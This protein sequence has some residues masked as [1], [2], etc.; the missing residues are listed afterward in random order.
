MVLTN[1]E[2][3]SSLRERVGRAVRRRWSPTVDGN[4]T[5]VDENEQPMRAELF[6]ISQIEQHAST[7]ASWHQVGFAGG[8]RADHLLLRLA[9]NEQALRDAHVLITEAVEHGTRITPAAE[10]FVDNYHL[11]EEQ[12]RTARR[13]LPRGFS[14]ELPRLANGPFAGTPR[15]YDIAIEL[16]SHSHGRVEIEG[17]RAFVASYQKVSPLRLGE[18]WAIPIML[19]LALIENLRR[20][21]AS[22]TAGRRDRARATH[23]VDRM[24]EIAASDPG[25]VVLILADMVRESPPLTNAFVTEFASRLRGQGAALVFPVSWLEHRLAENGQT[26]ERVFQLVSQNQAA[27]QV[28]IGNSIGSLRF[29]G[30]TDWRNF[31]EAMSVVERTLLADPTGVYATMDFA[32]RDCYRL[33]V[34]EISKRSSLSENDVAQAALQLSQDKPGGRQA[35]IGHFLIDAGRRLL[36]R[37]ARMRRTPRQVAC[38]IGQRLRFAGYASAVVGLTGILTGFL[39]IAAPTNALPTS[40]W[41]LAATLLVFALCSS[42]LSMSMV[43]WAATQ[44][45]LPRRLPRLDFSAGIPQGHSTVVAVPAMLTD[46]G[47][48]DSLVESLEVRFLANR[49]PRLFFALLTDFCDAQEERLAADDALLARAR[50]GIEALNRKYAGDGLPFFL[51]HRNRRWN[52]GEG[53]WMGWE[54][55][56]GKLEQFNDALRADPGQLPTATGFDAI[57]GDLGRLQ[58]VKYVI[59]LDSDTQLPRD[60]AQ[61]LA[62][63]MA[64]PLNC[65]VYDEGLGRVIDGY[66]ILQ[67]RVA[68]TMA[69]VGRSRFAR[70]F[71]GEPGIDPYTRAVSDV[72]QDLFNEGSFVGK[73]IYDVDSFR[74]AIGGKLPDNRILSHDLLEGAYGR[75]GLVSDITLFDD[76]PSSYAADV[77]RRYRW[78]RGDWQITPWL[79]PRVPGRDSS[80]QRNP[81]SWLSQWKILDNL[82]RT[83]VPIGLLSLL[84]Q[85]WIRPGA[86]VFA[87]LVL[88]AFLLLPGLL[89]A[90]TDLLHR[91]DEFPLR[92][93]VQEIGATV[94]RH[95]AREAF[96]L[97]C[98]PYDAFIA[99]TAMLRT[100][101][102]LLFTHRKLLEWRTASDAQRS[103]LT[104]LAGTYAAMWV[105]PFVALAATVGVVRQNPAALAV[106]A[107]VLG[108]WA[109]APVIAW[110]LS[111]PTVRGL[112]RLVPDDLVFLRTVARRTWRYFETFVGPEDNHLPPD[113]FQE[114]PPRG[115]AHRTSPTNIGLALTA[116]LVAY[117]FGYLSGTDV[118]ARTTCTLGAMDKLQRFRGHFY[119][120]YD[121]R[122]L[123]PLRPIYVSTVDSGNLSGHLITLGAGLHEMAGHKVFRTQIFAG[124]VDTLDVINDLLLRSASTSARTTVVRLREQLGSLPQTLSAS[125]ALLEGLLASGRDLVRT[126]GPDSGLAAA[127]DH[128]DGLSWWLGAFE[129]QCQRALEDLR[130]V[131]PWL[132]VPGVAEA[133]HADLNDALSRLDQI[134]SLADTARLAQTLVPVIDGALNARSSADEHTKGLT[135]L[136]AAVTLAVGR[137]SA[138]LSDLRLLIVRCREF[139]DID[140]QFLY[141]RERRMLAIGYSVSDHHLDPSFYDLLASEAR[142]A[143][144]VAI[145]QGKLPQE[146]WFSLGRLL[147]TSAGRPALLSWSGS[148]FEYLMPLLVMPTYE[149]TILDETY[150]GV[151][152][153]QIQHG[154]DRGVPW[155]VSESGYS[156]TD[157]QLN[158]QYR[159]F[160]VPG[161]GFKRGLANDLVIAPYASAMALMVAPTDACANL[162]RLARQGL[163]GA[164]GFYEAVDYTPARLLRGKDP[165]TVR[166]Y[167]AHHQGMSFLSLAYLLLDQPMQRRFN[168]EPAFRA[169]NL[170]LQERVPRTLAIHPHPAEVSAASEAPVDAPNSIRIFNTPATSSPA[171]H[172]LSNGSYHVAITNA[173]GGY[174]R[175]R[176]LAVTRWHEDPTRDCW[177]SFCYLRDVTSGAFWSVAH[178]PT[179]KAA[180]SY[181]AIYSQGRA[182]FRRRDGEIDTHVEISISPEDDIELRRVSLTNIGRTARTIELTSY[183]EVVLSQPAAD[184]AHPTFSN[185]FVQTELLRER[186]AILC[187]RRPRSGA[188]RPPWMLHLMTVLGTCVRATS[189]ETGRTEFIGRGRSAIDPAA[190]HRDALTDSQGSVLDP[191]VAIRNTIVIQPDETV[192]IHIVT[193]VAETRPGAIDLIEKYSD[194]HAADRVFDL[195]WTHSQVLLRQL[196]AAEADTQLYER[197]A[198]SILYANSTLRAPKSVIGRNR[199]GQS[200]LWAY[201]ISGDVPIALVRI[202]NADHMGLVRQMVKA[203]AYWRLK[204]LA[205]DLVILNEDTSGYRQVLQEEILAL[206]GSPAELSPLDRPGGIFVRRSDQM[207]EEDKVLMQTVARLIIGDSEGTLAEQLNR[208]VP[209]D[210]PAPLF[211][212]KGRRIDAAVVADVA[213]IAPPRSD[214]VQRTWWLHA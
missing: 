96:A 169:T 41:G 141:D 101:G 81:I 17:L 152:A 70:L 148:I 199:A 34:E 158:Y 204:G 123:E 103:S 16:I 51:L 105:A 149:G 22:I 146:H 85:G 178:Q 92:R 128:K 177:G 63:T 161:L 47:E 72:Y 49:D 196:D 10:W 115:S 210:M 214:R 36:E 173:G 4:G 35:H 162:R 94:A 143:S 186:Q 140:Y 79:W 90:G 14:R 138:R 163:L 88:A 191:V 48:I 29:L 181:E 130:H 100:A 62:G 58:A 102:R 206:V 12:I 164:Y 50:A 54:R 133:G 153:R 145:A 82:R 3:V 111:Q 155:G 9:S 5:G 30:A 71:G 19:R 160:G 76:Y 60:S 125:R 87:T 33:A 15:V 110:W 93:H 147:T 183:A 200:A 190:M 142:L 38:G 159:A 144:F 89:A 172:L 32:T 108:G 168:S 21:V 124:L 13:H 64:H 107:P 57:V 174:S 131:A 1:R 84:V 195:S 197:L 31:V 11:I 98:L 95:I 166:S 194:R 134:P 106:A 127:Q 188:E 80:S 122:T 129:T 207:S 132:D 27:H 211:P 180:T 74:R 137:A 176:D 175:W 44:L 75:S 201:G 118:I 185:L 46:I 157:A 7:L 165:V 205:A 28:S 97:A 120:W 170:L 78:M 126:T 189:Y 77:S 192:R 135:N 8:S 43:H 202:A 56:R 179:L 112:P 116:N 198:G 184:A 40:A 26:I 37:T 208:R 20:V 66:T 53:V 18:L 121:T 45:V 99:A 61:Q 73:G 209:V 171:V 104:D 119:N 212:G 114:D 65:P 113:N 213:S 139:S 25:K 187:T 154:N 52:P 167:M 55:K 39:A 91:P 86:G 182:E 23:W 193:G 42:Q 67:P 69:S 24:L 83:F 2:D 150:R 117:D 151:V 156:K 6:S 68:T 109:L 136:R 203:H 59:A